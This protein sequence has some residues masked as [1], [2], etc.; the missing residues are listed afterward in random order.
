MDMLMFLTMAVPSF[1]LITKTATAIQS[2]SILIL[3][4][5]GQGLVI[6]WKKGDTLR[7]FLSA[8]RTL[9]VH[10][11]SRIPYLRNRVKEGMEGPEGDYHFGLASVAEIMGW[12]FVKYLFL[13]L[14]FYFTGMALGVSLPWLQSFFFLPFVQLS[15]LVNVT[16]AG[17]GVMELGTYGALFLMG[18]SK[19]QI[20]VFVFG[21]RILLIVTFLALFALYHFFCLILRRKDGMT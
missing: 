20:L 12:N 7:F 4:V 19:P 14:R 8:Y 17:L 5:V 13:S 9:V 6:L 18:I 21:Q 3:L 1:L 15:G 10:G 2:L 11:F 16:P